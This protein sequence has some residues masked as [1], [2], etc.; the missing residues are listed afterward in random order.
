MTFQQLLFPFVFLPLAI[1]LFRVTPERFRKAVLV[2]LSLVFIAW[3][4]PSDLLFVGLSAVFNYFSGL[5]LVRLR[6]EN[7]QKQ[8]R[9]VKPD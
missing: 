6:E 4:N 1:L 3:G 5:E 8:A 7:R 2:L 9:T